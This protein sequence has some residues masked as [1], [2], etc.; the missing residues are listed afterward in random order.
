ME[1]NAVAANIDVNNKMISSQSN[2]THANGNNAIPKADA[3]GNINTMAEKLDA[4]EGRVQNH[5]EQERDIFAVAAAAVPAPG[6]DDAKGTAIDNQQGLIQLHT[7][8]LRIDEKI[9]F[10]MT[11]MLTSPMLLLLRRM[12]R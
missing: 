2:D 9:L 5:H 4:D 6:E 11:Q 1:A 3:A 8:A 12:S 10:M 7:I